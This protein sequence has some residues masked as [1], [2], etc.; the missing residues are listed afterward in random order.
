MKY[1]IVKADLEA[2][3]TECMPFDFSN[4]SIHPEELAK[5]L[6]ETMYSNNGLGLA[7]IQCGIPL[8]VF[9]MRGNE[10]DF[11]C[12]NPRVVMPSTETIR[13]EEACLSWP[14][15][16][17][18]IERPQH[19]RVRFADLNGDVDT[20]LFTGLTAR[21]FQHEMTHVNSRVFWE[22]MKRYRVQKAIKK[23]QKHGYDYEGKG[24]LRYA[25]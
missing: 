18:N 12:F 9:A 16:L 2:L 3:T 4:P 15:L 11:V 6:V 8:K 24:L 1:D 5:N 7:A 20:H 17:L 13:L 22:N 25:E 14:G 21:I 23:A 10:H 19:V